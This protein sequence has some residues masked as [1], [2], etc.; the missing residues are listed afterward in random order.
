MQGRIEHIAQSSKLRPRSKHAAL[1]AAVRG[2]AFMTEHPKV[3]MT[4]E[5]FEAEEA[6]QAEFD[7]RCANLPDPNE[8]RVDG[9]IW[10]PE[11]DDH[12]LLKY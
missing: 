9:E 4:V 3:K 8:Q 7:A 2:S 11:F 12:T 1:K 6:K 5:E 10:H